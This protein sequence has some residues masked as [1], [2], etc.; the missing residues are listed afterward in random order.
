MT[1]K[2]MSQSWSE[3]PDDILP[4]DRARVECWFTE[5]VFIVEVQYEYRIDL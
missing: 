4:R 2:W 5:E 3:F 1:D